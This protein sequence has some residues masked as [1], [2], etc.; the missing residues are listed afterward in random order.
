MR[1]LF[2]EFLLF[3]IRDLS[4]D[5]THKNVVSYVFFLS[6]IMANV[7]MWFVLS[8]NVFLEDNASLMYSY[9]FFFSYKQKI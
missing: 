8:T 4:H 6:T 3:Y 7:F 2:L 5:R 1:V 9:S